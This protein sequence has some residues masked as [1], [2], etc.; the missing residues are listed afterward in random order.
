MICLPFYDGEGS[1]G[2]GEPPA[3]GQIFVFNPD[4]QYQGAVVH[5]RTG[6][7]DAFVTFDSPATARRGVWCKYS[8]LI[9]TEP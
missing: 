4:Q 1:G 3:P 9:W 8:D 6:A 5:L 2:S 7:D